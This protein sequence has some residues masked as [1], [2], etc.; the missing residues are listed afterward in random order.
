MI[1]R[2]VVVP[3]NRRKYQPPAIKTGLYPCDL[4]P[5]TERRRD[6]GSYELLRTVSLHARENQVRGVAICLVYRD[7]TIEVG[8]SGIAA[9]KPMI[10]LAITARLASFLRKLAG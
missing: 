7:G 4:E 1:F 9:T 6:T 2:E 8:A 10:G 5:S 3:I